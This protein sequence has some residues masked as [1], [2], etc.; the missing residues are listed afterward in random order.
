MKLVKK[1]QRAFLDANIAPGTSGAPVVYGTIVTANKSVTQAASTATDAAG[2]VVDF[3]AL[4]AKL[5]TA[6]IVL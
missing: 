1:S 2:I 6:G 3:N 5:K 4:L